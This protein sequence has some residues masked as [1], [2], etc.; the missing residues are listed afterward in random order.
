M[1]DI[2]Y[3][4]FEPNS[5]CTSYIQKLVKLN[6]FNKVTIQCCAL[7]NRVQT[8]ELEKTLMDDSRASVITSLRPGYFSEKE[9][10]LSLDYDLFWSDLKISFVKID[11]EGSELEVLRGM[12][13]SINKYNPVIVCEVLDSHDE[14]VFEFTQTRATQL[15]DFLHS[16]NYSII[17]LETCK[18]K[19]NLVSFKQIDSIVTKQWTPK[20]SDY[21]DYLFYPSNIE[22]EV[23]KKLNSIKSS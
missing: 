23:L 19:H 11:V 5:T 14:S 18:T 13:K 3:L 7:S 6:H 9:S 22:Q 17:Q 4:G 20:S 10:V 1:P 8:L 2:G 21:N 15:S 12:I 16:T